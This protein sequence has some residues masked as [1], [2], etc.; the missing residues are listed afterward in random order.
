MDGWKTQVKATQDMRLFWC[1]FIALVTTSFGFIIRSFSIGR[2]GHEFG[3]T[4]T[5]QG[6]ILGVGIWPFAISIVVFSLIVDRIGYKTALWIAFA[7]HVTSIALTVAADSY[8]TLYWATGLAA[9]GAGTVE[10]VGNP[11]I[12]TL[13]KKDKVK[14]L[15]IFHAGWPGGLALAGMLVIF[16]KDL[17]WEAHIL[18]MLI[19]TFAYGAL[20]LRVK[21]PVNERVAAGVSYKDMLREMGAIGILGVS[22]LVFFE[23]ARVISGMTGV[24]IPWWVTT[25]V[26]IAT[27]VFYFRRVGSLGRP[28]FILLQLIMIPLAITELSTDGWVT[29]LMAPEMGILGLHAGWVIVYTSMI[30]VILRFF[31]GPVV[32]AFTPLG[33]L[34]VCSVLAGTGLYWLSSAHFGLAIVAAATLYGVAKAYLWPTMLGVTAERFPRGGALTL[35]SIGGLGMLSAGLIGTVFLGLSQ[36]RAIDKS[37]QAYDDANN[38]AL[39]EAYVTQDKVSML[40]KYRALDEARLAT[41]PVGDKVAVTHAREI[42]K[43]EAMKTVAVLPLL[44]LAAYL[45]LLLYFRMKGGY[46]P[47][48]LPSSNP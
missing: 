21:F 28:M 41:A 12:A 45:L 36:D 13:F 3:L 20:L 10:S 39:H 7:C 30:M 22:A 11:V 43:K 48:E 8:W 35:N 38:T 42:A 26:V 47:V 25:L 5:Q 2:W 23:I 46:R 17:P 16:L 9:I 29:E 19:P 15:N 1:V 4:A 18:L 27:S 33:L 6:E 14:W 24:E 37:V 44:M 32:K 40:G 31:A 34:A